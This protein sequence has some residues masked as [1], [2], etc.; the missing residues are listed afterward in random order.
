M[1]DIAILVFVCIS[2]YYIYFQVRVVLRVMRVKHNSKLYGAL[3]CAR[4]ALIRKAYRHVVHV[5]WLSCLFIA[6][7]VIA[8]SCVSQLLWR[9]APCSRLPTLIHIRDC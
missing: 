3:R 4:E 2:K 1:R 9:D 8:L 6:C 7:T 5:M